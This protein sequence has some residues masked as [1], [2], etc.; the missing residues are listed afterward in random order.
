MLYYVLSVSPVRLECRL[1]N[2]IEAK[3]YHW[4][5]DGQLFSA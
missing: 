2:E 4:R 1:T 5:P 3:T